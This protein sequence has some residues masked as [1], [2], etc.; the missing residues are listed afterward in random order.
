[1]LWNPALKTVGESVI[2]WGGRDRL[3]A[4]SP[5]RTP[6]LSSCF[7]IGKRKIGFSS[8]QSLAVFQSFHS[9]ALSVARFQAS[10]AFPEIAVLALA[11]AVPAGA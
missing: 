7:L 5:R 1:L 11:D 8:E 4:I 3:R 6:L 9:L 10:P 2:A